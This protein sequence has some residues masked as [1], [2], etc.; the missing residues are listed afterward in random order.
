MEILESN[1]LKLFRQNQVSVVQIL[2]GDTVFD[3]FVIL[4][5][6]HPLG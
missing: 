2:A 1:T 4:W 5:H 6:F 3:S